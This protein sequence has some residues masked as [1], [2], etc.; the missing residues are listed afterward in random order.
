[1]DDPGNEQSTSPSPSVAGMQAITI[2]R[3]YGSGG[4]EIAA[5]LATRLGWQLVDHQIVANVAK[6]L[7]ETNEEAAKR[8]EQQVGSFVIRVIDGLQWIAPWSGG[9]PAYTAE[10]DLRRH[11]EALC[12]V[13]GSVIEIGHVVIVG[14]GAQVLL[15]DR[16]DVLHV[17]IVA[18]IERRVAY[19]ASRESL[20]ADKA[21]AR[22]KSKDGDRANYL[23]SVQRRSPDDPLL[24]DLVVNTAVLSLDQA[25]DLIAAALDAKA[26]RLDVPDGDLGPGAGLGPY[27]A[28][29]SEL[30]LQSGDR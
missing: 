26:A 3:E 8:D 7:N 2:S 14:R 15:K 4:G 30:A 11:F 20:P 17:R 1:M 24:Y 19:L 18:P 29:P 16:R 13:V 12:K 22:I 27:P 23:K 10:T 28:P 5:R 9:Q 6:A 21:Q 25:V